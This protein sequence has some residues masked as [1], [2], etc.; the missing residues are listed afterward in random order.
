MRQP[1]IIAEYHASFT[2]AQTTAREWKRRIK[3]GKGTAANDLL[4]LAVLTKKNNKFNIIFI[5]HSVVGDIHFFKSLDAW[6]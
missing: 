1:F 4:K 3:R 6:V 2:F 5:E